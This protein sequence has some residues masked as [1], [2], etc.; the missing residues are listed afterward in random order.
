MLPFYQLRSA[1]DKF[2]TY[3]RP[4]NRKG[5]TLSEITAKTLMR[6]SNFLSKNF[7]TN[8]IMPTNLKTG[9]KPSPANLKNV[10]TVR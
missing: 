8:A 1:N 5:F 7:Q 4:P 9:Q 2:M 6:G 3:L 10:P